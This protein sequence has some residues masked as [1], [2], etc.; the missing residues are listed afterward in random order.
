MVAGKTS[1]TNEQLPLVNGRRV[2]DADLIEQVT[3]AIVEHFHPNRIILFGSQAR[4]DARPDSDLDLFVEMETSARPVERMIAIDAIFG[5]RFWPMDL[6][7]YTPEE[8]RQMRRIKGSFLNQIEAEG[9]LLYEQ[10]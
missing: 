10:P 2:I 7:V 8:V 9:A 5:L 1:S 4:G 3:R 6:V